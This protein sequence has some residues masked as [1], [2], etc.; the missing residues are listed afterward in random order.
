MKV[1]RLSDRIVVNFETFSIK[2]KPLSFEERSIIESFTK[3]VAGE[4]VTDWNKT[5]FNTIKYCVASIDGL[6]DFNDRPIECEIKD[7]YISDDMVNIIF[8]SSMRSDILRSIR[9]IEDN[10]EA[11]IKGDHKIDSIK[12][13][14]LGN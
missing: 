10:P 3:I 11:F 2:I 13:V 5:L 14:N 4:N 7:G 6:K 1:L 9:L 8:N 12:G